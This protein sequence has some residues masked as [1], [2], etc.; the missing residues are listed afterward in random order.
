MAELTFAQVDAVLKY[1]PET[2]NLFWKERPLE[3]FEDS[4]GRA[5]RTHLLWN[6]RY[7]GTEAFTSANRQGYKYGSIYWRLY[8]AHRVAW[9]LH[10]GKW[11][12]GDIDHLNGDG[13]DN[14]ISNL[15]DGTT[16]QNMLNQRRYKNNGSGVTGVSWRSRNSRWA[17]YVDVDGKR[18]NLGEFRAFEDAVT[19]RKTANIELG[20][21][22]RHGT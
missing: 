16:S 2:G 17:A 5:K 6:R 12:D 4:R 13:G 11:P 3:L 20:F 22:P 7:A 19:A 10:H 1:E 8:K 9:L 14:R 15:R 21:S 18:K